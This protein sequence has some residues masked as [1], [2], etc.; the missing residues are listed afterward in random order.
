MVPWGKALSIYMIMLAVY[1]LSF[2]CSFQFYDKLATKLFTFQEFVGI[3][4][5]LL[6]I[7]LGIGLTFNIIEGCSLLS[8]TAE[9]YIFIFWGTLAIAAYF[10]VSMIHSFF[11]NSTSEEAYHAI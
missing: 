1:L 2:N 7:P 11:T 8:L 3:T 5:G 9:I 4:L 10:V 6:N